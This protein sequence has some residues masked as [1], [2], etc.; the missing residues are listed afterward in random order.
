MT[1]QPSSLLDRLVSACFSLLAAV[2]ALYV[3]AHLLE[4]I[5]P[6][7]VGLALSGLAVAGAVVA[8]RRRREGW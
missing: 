8:F 6:V 2:L 4:S 1:Y 7:L 5:W 3:A